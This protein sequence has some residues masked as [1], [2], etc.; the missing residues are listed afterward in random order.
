VAQ[1]VGPEFKAQYRN[2]QKE[3]R[4]RL[5]SIMAATVRMMDITEVY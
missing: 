5:S 2:K 1:G 3:N 4:V